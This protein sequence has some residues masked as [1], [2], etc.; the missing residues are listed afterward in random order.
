MN[1]FGGQDSSYDFFQILTKACVRFILAN[2]DVLSSS[3]VDIVNGDSRLSSKIISS[4][5]EEARDMYFKAQ[6]PFLKSSFRVQL[7]SVLDFPIPNTSRSPSLFVEC[8]G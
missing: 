5:H 6:V 3:F 4:I 2:F 8:R 7:K 1:C